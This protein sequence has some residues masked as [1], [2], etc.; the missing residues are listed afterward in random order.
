MALLVE[1]G[2]GGLVQFPATITWTDVSTFADG[3]VNGIVVT[4]GAAD[5]LSETQ[6]GSATLRL[7]NQDG[8]F[9][10]GNAA[11]PYYPYVRRNAPIRVS[12]A[13]IPTVSGSAPYPL[14]ML[15]DAFDDGRIDPSVWPVATGGATETAEGRLRI[16]LAPGVDTNFTSVRQWKLAGSKLTAKLATVPAVNGSSNVA[17]SMWVTSTTSGTRIGWRYDALAGVISAQSQTSFADG[18]AV[19][20]TYSAID[21]GWLRVREASGTV[22]WETSGDG[23]TWTVRRTLATPSWVTSQT[24]AVDFPTT[25]TGGTTGYVEWDLIGAE[26]RPRFYGMVNEFPVD[27][28]GLL[29]TVTITCTDLFKRLN[30]LPALRSAVTEET[31]ESGPVAY[32]PLTEPSDSLSAGDLSGLGAGSLTIQQAGSGGTL[33]MS[34]TDGPPASGDQVP[35]FTP[36]TA[37]AGKWLMA[38]MGSAVQQQLT[39]NWPVFE[40]WF[41][42]TTTG[43]AMLGLAS[44]DLRYVHVLSLSA[45]GALQI[46]W[47]NLGVTSLTV[48]TVDGTSGLADGAWHHVIYDQNAGAVW[49]DGTLRDSALAVTYGFDQRILHVGGYRNTRLW[50]G[51]V[52]HVA[53]YGVSVSTGASLTPHYT[54]GTTAFAGED[55]DV[56]IQ[57]LARYAGIPSVTIAGTTHDPIASQGEGGSQVVA[58][59]RE[60]E[61][62]ESGHLFAARDFYGLEY[63][64][65]DV[66]YNPI[67]AAESFTIDYADLEPGTS[68]ADDD[69]KLVNSVEAARPGGATQ[70]VSAPQSVFAFG[71]YPQTLN[72]LKTSDNS[73]L[74]AAYWLVSRYANP[75]PELREAVIEA[76]TMPGYLAILD[77]DISSYFTVYNL[78]SQAPASSLRVT[79]EGYTETL[80]ERSHIIQFHTSASVNDSVWVLDDSVYSVLGST[81]RLAY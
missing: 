20:L 59:M 30:R 44:A 8:R 66:R 41:Q 72:I 81:T 47:T 2:W 60:V 22:Y 18:S 17:A 42:T 50:A 9:T 45:S 39:Q 62:T 78:P 68:L 80:K 36:S 65:R 29:S 71:A 75:G 70:R 5:E 58:R 52:A 35:V 10:P 33:T 31:L 11:S 38:D 77:A 25:R 51:S 46:E 23:Y 4:R 14:A 3:I 34:N 43:R 26:I 48:E 28:E 40:C 69:Q 49:V 55:A 15:G 37:T 1:M 21:H 32:Y 7:D 63:Q 76:Y 64:S 54:A 74:D 57:R 53:L 73:V 79:V 61:S 67:P 6:P 16:P 24:H 27:W 13:V 19:N 12:V 56:R